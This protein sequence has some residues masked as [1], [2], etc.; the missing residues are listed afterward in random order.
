MGDQIMDWARPLSPQTTESQRAEGIQHIRAFMQAL[1]VRPV[2]S[3]GKGE[4][5]SPKKPLTS[6]PAP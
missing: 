3:M 1:T 5:R 4:S 6:W 2:K